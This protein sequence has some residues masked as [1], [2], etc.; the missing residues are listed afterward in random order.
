MEDK[1]VKGK[2]ARYQKQS[3]IISK[4]TRQ[5]GI[6]DNRAAAASSMSNGGG[7]GDGGLHLF[8]VYFSPTRNIYIYRKI[9][10]RTSMYR[11]IC[12]TNVLISIYL[13]IYKGRLSCGHS[14]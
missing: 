8:S 9:L 14:F 10:K 12:M 2:R 6:H 5:L 13:Y 11:L 4:L 1:N 3:S 7:A